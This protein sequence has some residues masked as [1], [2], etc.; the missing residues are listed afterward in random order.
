MLADPQTLTVNAVAKVCARIG[1]N[2]TTADYVE[3]E[4]LFSLRTQRIALKSGDT[5][6]AV[7]FQQKK[8]S[9]DPLLEGVSQWRRATVSFAVTTPPAGYTAAEIA[10]LTDA[11]L[12]WL[13]ASTD[14]VVAQL[15]AG[16]I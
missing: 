12:D 15:A 13:R 11:F 8:V 14:A 5:R 3:P 10:L 9:A 4:G 2:E 1:S 6:H 16:Q 7:T